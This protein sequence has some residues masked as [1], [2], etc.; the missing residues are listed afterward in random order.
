[1]NSVA[2]RRL[3]IAIVG[4]ALIATSAIIFA[5][6]RGPFVCNQCALQT[7]LPDRGTRNFI[8]SQR[9]FFEIPLANIGDTYVIC[10]VS[11]CVTYRL[12]ASNEFVGDEP[13]P[14]R[15]APRN[16]R[17]REGSISGTLTD[18]ARGNTVPGGRGTTTSTNSSPTVT[19]PSVT[20]T[21]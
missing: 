11:A 7:P 2:R 13:R 15:D 3:A 12:T 8:E 18:N 4:A 20:R 6:E 19:I 17:E 14:I 5:I 21:Q 9:P 10:N 16:G 1:M